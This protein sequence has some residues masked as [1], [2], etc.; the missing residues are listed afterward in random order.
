ML[1]VRPRDQKNFFWYGV[2]NFPKIE[3]LA[4]RPQ[5]FLLVSWWDHE[6][7]NFF[8]SHGETTRNSFGGWYAI[9]TNL[10]ILAVRLQWQHNLASNCL[11]LDSLPDIFITKNNIGLAN[12]NMH[13][14]I[15][16]VYALFVLFLSSSELALNWRIK[17]QKHSILL[18]LT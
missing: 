14:L 3:M 6:H 17:Q 4:V 11:T 7:E 5:E 9:L 16:Y 12:I 2:C 1:V 13:L 18:I 8:W 10:K 15:Y